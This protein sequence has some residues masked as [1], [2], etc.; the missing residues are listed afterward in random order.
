MRERNRKALT[1]DDRSTLAAVF[2]FEAGQAD[3]E[4]RVAKWR[5]IANVRKRRLQQQTMRLRAY[6]RLVAG[7]VERRTKRCS[8]SAEELRYIDQQLDVHA[9]ALEP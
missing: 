5:Q 1:I 4:A 7:I 3:A 2:G 8:N 6:A 9:P